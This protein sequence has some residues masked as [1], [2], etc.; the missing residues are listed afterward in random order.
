MERG[1]PFKVLETASIS[2]P[3]LDNLSEKVSA[4]F[5]S[6]PDNLFVSSH[7]VHT[8]HFYS[9]VIVFQRRESV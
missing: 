3:T 8:E 2:S 9:M 5:S 7:F 4:F 1:I 6:N